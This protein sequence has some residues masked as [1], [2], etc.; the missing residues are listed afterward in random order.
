[1]F[2]VSRPVKKL[3]ERLASIC[4]IW[5]PRV[6]AFDGGLQAAVIDYAPNV[7]IAY[8]VDNGS[9]HRVDLMIE[10]GE[11]AHAADPQPLG[12]REKQG[13]EIVHMVVR[14][15]IEGYRNLLNLSPDDP[16]FDDFAPMRWAAQQAL[17][18]LTVGGR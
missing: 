1:M 4:P 8:F 5:D 9:W 18:Y 14:S 13:D 15:T 12:V 2:G 17:P 3:A 6:M 11:V 16:L 10:D 7:R